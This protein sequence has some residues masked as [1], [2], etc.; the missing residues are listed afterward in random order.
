ME[1]KCNEHHQNTR[2]MVATWYGF[3]E[4]AYVCEE[5]EREKLWWYIIVRGDREDVYPIKHHKSKVDWNIVVDSMGS[6]MATNMF[7]FLI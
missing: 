6:G 5:S 2:M 3:I 4:M 7:L 1:P